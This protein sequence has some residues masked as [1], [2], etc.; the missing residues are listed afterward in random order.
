MKRLFQLVVIVVALAPASVFAQDQPTFGLSGIR[1]ASFSPQRAFSESAEGKDGLARLNALQQKRA[2][3]IEQRNRALVAEE[4]A[5]Q[6]MLTQ[7]GRTQRT[8]ALEKMRLDTQRLIQ[9]AQAELLGLQRDIED[10][11]AMK[12]RPAIERVAMEK[13]LQ[14][15]VNLD[16]PTVVWADPSLDITADVIT[17]LA[18][19]R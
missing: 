2:G 13:K 17:R 16:D 7:D 19:N 8:K 12:L 1:L 11:F 3:E 18:Q 14:L 4:Q 15:I 9:D 6:Q 5:L 10:A